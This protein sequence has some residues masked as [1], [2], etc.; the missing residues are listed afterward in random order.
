MFT[1]GYPRVAFLSRYV[2]VN[3]PKWAKRWGESVESVESVE[4]VSV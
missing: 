1:V 3:M 2:E 4:L